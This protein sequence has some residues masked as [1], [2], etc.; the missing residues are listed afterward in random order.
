M[1]KKGREEE[2]KEKKGKEEQ[3][4]PPLQLSIPLLGQ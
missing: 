1:Q 4:I 2:I 3:K